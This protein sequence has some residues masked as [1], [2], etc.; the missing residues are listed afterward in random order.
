MALSVD[1]ECKFHVHA[2][3]SFRMLHEL[4]KNHSASDISDLICIR[5][6]DG[7]SVRRVRTG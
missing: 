1:L 5:S 2:M 4:C 6:P 3:N 7:I